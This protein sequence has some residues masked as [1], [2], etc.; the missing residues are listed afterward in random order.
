MRHVTGAGRLRSLP[1]GCG[2]MSRPS[3]HGLTTLTQ[4]HAPVPQARGEVRIALPQEA[5][6]LS[7][8]R[9]HGRLEICL[10]GP[11]FPTGRAETCTG[12][13]LR[14]V[15]GFAHHSSVAVHS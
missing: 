14:R 5:E 3:G 15:N 11:F 12:R 13:L 1:L 4:Q 2:E 9:G 7:V 8:L 6:A 10:A